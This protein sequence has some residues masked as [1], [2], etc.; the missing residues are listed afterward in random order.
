MKTLQPVLDTVPLASRPLSRIVVDDTE[1][2]YE[3]RGSG[4]PV[5]L[6]HG[7]ILAE[8]FAPLLAERALTDRYRVINYHRRGF[9]GSAR[10][11]G[12]VSIA[13][14][15]ADAH[16]VLAHLG[17][18]RAHVVAHSYG[19]AIAL[20]LALDAPAAVHS[21]A[22]LE[23]PLFAVPSGKQFIAAVFGSAMERYAAGDRAGAVGTVLRGVAGAAGIAAVQ[24][25][26][27]GA[28]E[29][30]EAD[31]ATFFQTELPALQAW[32]FTSR[33]ARRIDQPLLAVRG[34]DSDAVT[35]VFGEGV[36]MVREWLPQAEAFVIPE[37]THG[38]PFMNPCGL[39]DGLTAFFARYPLPTQTRQRKDMVAYRVRAT[40]QRAS[41]SGFNGA[42][43]KTAPPIDQSARSATQETPAGAI[44]APAGPVKFVALYG[45]PADPAAFDRYYAETNVPLAHQLPGLRRV[46]TA[47][48]LGT[49]QGGTAPYYRTAEL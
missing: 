26:L 19:G 10:P 38:M 33:E 17:I 25:A 24:R 36:A 11:Q 34:A 12:V 30:A 6:I 42:G 8:A 2:E 4:E 7:G 16:A 40:D 9:A 27:P 45:P 3:E 20:Q 1:L 39:A 23:P 48:I 15:A 5:L 49:A 46:E 43:A 21:L 37:A 44:P 41:P 29:L 28:L 47:Q 35:P 13:R 32:C 31:A 22:L 14:Q 18:T